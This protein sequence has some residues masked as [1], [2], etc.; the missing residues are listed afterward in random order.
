MIPAAD[1]K[2]VQAEE[3]GVRVILGNEG[4]GGQRWGT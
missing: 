4:E 2:G 3:E 1:G